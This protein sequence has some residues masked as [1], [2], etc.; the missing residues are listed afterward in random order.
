VSVGFRVRLSWMGQLVDTL[1]D[2]P[3]AE[4]GI[5]L[6]G[7]NPAPSSVEAGHYYQGQVGQGWNLSFGELES[8][9][10]TLRRLELG[11]E[12]LGN[13]R[14][15]QTVADTQWQTW[16]DEQRHWRRALDAR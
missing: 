14:E 6:V 10:K 7:I 4:G 13:M 1:T 12:L 11:T 3:P 5:V 15:A 9:S 16:F 8:Y 2:V